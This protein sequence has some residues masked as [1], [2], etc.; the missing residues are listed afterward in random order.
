MESSQLAFR[1][2]PVLPLVA[3]FP[4]ALFEQLVGATRDLVAG[5]IVS[6]LDR[7]RGVFR[8][9]RLAG[10]RVGNLMQRFSIAAAARYR[11]S[12]PPYAEVREAARLP[13]H[14]APTLNSAA[15]PPSL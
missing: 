15:F 13:V 5:R 4:T 2:E 11:H 6:A 12:S 3:W 9:R 1:S 14:L 7:T 8:R 10:S